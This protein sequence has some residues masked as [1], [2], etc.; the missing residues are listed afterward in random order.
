MRQKQEVE[1]LL[2]Q[3]P[4]LRALRDKLEPTLSTDPGH[5][6]AHAIRVAAWTLRLGDSDVEPREVVAA[7]L[8]HDSVNLP[9]DSPRRAEASTLSAELA[10]REL[11]KL[12][13]SSEAIERVAEAVRDHSYSR[14]AVPE[15]ALG[16]A[17]QDAD[18]LEALGAIGLMRCVAVNTKM[19]G[20]FFDPADPW[21]RDRQLQDRRYF[22][23]HFFTKLLQLPE[24]MCTKAGRVEARRRAVFLR[25]FLDQ[26][27]GE[28]GEPRPD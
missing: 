25:Q 7:A 23:D 8:L 21:A 6:L 24:T 28:I 3:D 27:A 14:G 20:Q 16:R 13:F 17:L 9:K 19:Q 26:L 11:A 5:D 15:E 18:R 1:R 22:V 10:R 2:V 12:D 4:A